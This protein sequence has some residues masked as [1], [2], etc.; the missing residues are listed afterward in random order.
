MTAITEDWSTVGFLANDPM[1]LADLERKVICQ[2]ILTVARATGGIVTA[3]Q[4][5]GAL[6]RKVN[7]HRLGAIINSLAQSGALVDTNRTAPSGDKANRNS[8]RRL[9]VWYAPNL[10]AIK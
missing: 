1:P 7:P 2:A 5:R 3:A 9:P 4:I 10:E 6:E 8:R